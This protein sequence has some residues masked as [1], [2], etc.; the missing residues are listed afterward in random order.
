M[1][2]E[3][4]SINPRFVM[5]AIEVRRGNQLN[6]I[7]IAGLVPGQEGEMVSCV[8]LIIGCHPE[9]AVATEGPRNCNTRQSP[10]RNTTTTSSV[11]TAE[12]GRWPIVRLRA[13]SRRSQSS[14]SL[15][16]NGV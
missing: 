5:E 3:K 14:V 13:L 6:Q 11:L 8:A 4:A 1:C 7:A 9:V 12:A 15:E 2:R 10:Q 16:S